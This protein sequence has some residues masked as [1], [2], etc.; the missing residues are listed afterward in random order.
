MGFK[1]LQRLTTWLASRLWYSEIV[2]H[3]LY[4]SDPNSCEVS[5]EQV[6]LCSGRLPHS[7]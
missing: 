5:L 6:L 2:M 7:P 4:V 1:P 3:K